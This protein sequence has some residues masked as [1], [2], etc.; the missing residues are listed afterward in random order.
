MRNMSFAFT[1]EQVRNQTKTVTRRLGWR[2]LKVGDLVQ[3]VEKG[4]GLKKGEKVKKIGPP[5]RV[6]GIR[7]ERLDMVLH[8]P[9]ATVHEGLPFMTQHEFLYRFSR[10]NRCDPDADIARIEFEYTGG[11]GK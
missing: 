11:P 3:P 7:R 2:F 10:V 4:M 5:I 6:V 9:A 1:I 8:E